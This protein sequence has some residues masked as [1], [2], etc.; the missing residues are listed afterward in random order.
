MANKSLIE[1][2]LKRQEEETKVEVE[3]KG[4]ADTPFYVKINKELYK[5]LEVEA[6]QSQGEKEV[7]E[8]VFLE[9]LNALVI[10]R[11]LHDHNEEPVFTGELYEA[12]GTW[13][14]VEVV[15][16]VVTLAEEQVIHIAAKECLG[17]VRLDK[18]QKEN[19]ELKN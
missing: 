17:F 13:D 19:D 4:L 11:S 16:K 6:G 7:P 18:V 12:L 14:A 10:V 3:L 2:L 9:R 15:K 8:K 5:E 1:K